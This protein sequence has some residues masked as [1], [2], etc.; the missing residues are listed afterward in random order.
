MVDYQVVFRIE[1]EYGYACTGIEG[2]ERLGNGS[3]FLTKTPA[4]SCKD[5][6]EQ[7]RFG[8]SRYGIVRFCKDGTYP[9]YC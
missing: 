4:V 2:A 5:A 3:W 8:F 1:T 6:K 9:V 7:V